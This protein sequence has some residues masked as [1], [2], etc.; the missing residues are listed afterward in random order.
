MVA[1]HWRIFPNLVIIRT[2]NEIWAYFY[3]IFLIPRK[4]VQVA[5]SFSCPRRTVLDERLK[6]GEYSTAALIGTLLH[7]IFQVS[8]LPRAPHKLFDINSF[9]SDWHT[10][11]GISFF[12]FPQAGLM[13]EIPTINFLKEY[14]TVVLQK[15][16][17]SLYACGGGNFYNSQ[18]TTISTF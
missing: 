16:I 9:F 2:L 18:L 4:M 14:A 3:F 11:C 1:L 10:Q 7:Q 15:N 6:F 17:E 5:A 12:F 8:K 13:K